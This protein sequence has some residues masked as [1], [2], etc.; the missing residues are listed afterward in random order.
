MTIIHEYHDIATKIWPMQTQ[1]PDTT[2]ITQPKPPI[3]RAGL[4][5]ISRLAKLRNECNK[6]AKLNPEAS[7]DHEQNPIYINNKI[8]TILNPVHPISTS[9]AHKQCNKAIGTIVRHASNTLNEKLRDKEND[10]Y[11]KSPKQCHNNLTISAG[12]LPRA[13]DQ[14]K[15]TALRHPAT[16]ITPNT[17]QAVI[18]IVTTH[19]TK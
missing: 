4:R 1:R 17:P 15:V 3:S 16:N 7:T 5:Q 14:P 19:Y 12:L 9:E 8:N 6:T 11:D 2:T 13:K 18:D 10:S